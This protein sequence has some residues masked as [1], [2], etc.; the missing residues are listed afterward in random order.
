MVPQ[1]E[2]VNV[3]VQGEEEV[4]WVEKEDAMLLD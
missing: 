3:E 4:T 1:R 2:M